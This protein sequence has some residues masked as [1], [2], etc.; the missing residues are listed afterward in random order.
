[1]MLI[2]AHLDRAHVEPVSSVT[3]IDVG[4]LVLSAAAIH[5]D[6][7]SS[8]PALLRSALEARDRLLDLATFI[9]IRWGSIVD[10]NEAAREKCA[11]R[12]SRWRERLESMQGMVEMTFKTGGKGKPVRPDFRSASSGRDYLQKLHDMR[13]GVE[14]DAGLLDRAVTLFTPLAADLRQLRREDGGAEIA[15][16]VPRERLQSVAEAGRRLQEEKPE[17]PFLL[18][19]PWPLEVFAD[20]Q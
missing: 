19:G 10:S 14:I 3:A 20:E 1:M 7:G 17:S 15:L 11:T 4:E 12:I 6:R 13:R 16:L 9:A 2:G 18:S 5:R 8:D